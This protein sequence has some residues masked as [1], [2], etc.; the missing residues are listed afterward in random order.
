MISRTNIFFLIILFYKHHFQI[1]NNVIRIVKQKVNFI[2]IRGI[3]YNFYKL[4][5]MNKFTQKLFKNKL[6]KICMFTIK[7]LK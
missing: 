7:L 1:L 2:Y 5:F 3:T 6:I 4:T